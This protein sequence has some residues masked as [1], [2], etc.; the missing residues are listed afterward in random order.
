MS[1]QS[2]ARKDAEEEVQTG[3]GVLLE[4][5]PPPPPGRRSAWLMHVFTMIAIF[6]LDFGNSIVPHRT[7]RNNISAKADTLYYVSFQSFLHCVCEK[8]GVRS[9]PYPY[10]STNIPGAKSVGAHSGDRFPPSHPKLSSLLL[11][12]LFLFP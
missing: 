3:Y 9:T 1:L 6:S 4:G 12:F 10:Q 2:S 8:F 11:G 7:C 5:K